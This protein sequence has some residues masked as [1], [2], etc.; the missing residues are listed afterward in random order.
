MS[1]P[2]HAPLTWIRALWPNDDVSIPLYF[3]SETEVQQLADHLCDVP[4]D[5]FDLVM[6]RERS[7][8]RQFHNQKE[9]DKT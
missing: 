6:R 4:E 1:L 9:G 8:A 3:V 5:F 7:I 2:T